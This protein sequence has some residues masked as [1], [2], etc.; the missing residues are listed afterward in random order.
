MLIITIIVVSYFSENLVINDRKETQCEI[1]YLLQSLQ[2]FNHGHSDIFCLY[3]LSKICL[4]NGTSNIVL[5]SYIFFTQLLNSNHSA[6]VYTKACF[7]KM[8]Y[9]FALILFDSCSRALNTGARI[10]MWNAADS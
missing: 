3:V 4:Q 8:S 6:N 9:E 5:F 1:K 7:N 10:I 2:D